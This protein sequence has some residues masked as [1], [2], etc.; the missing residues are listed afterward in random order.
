MATTSELVCILGLSA[1]GHLRHSLTFDTI[2]LVVG[3][4]CLQGDQEL[5][6]QTIKLNTIGDV[7]AGE[8]EFL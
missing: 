1:L 2:Y 4:E 7:G 6:V 5:V 8:G 3:G